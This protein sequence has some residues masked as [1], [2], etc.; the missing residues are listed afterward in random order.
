MFDKEKFL[1]NI[2]YFIILYYIFC[3]FK[4][5]FH[6]IYKKKSL[7][8]IRIHMYCAKCIFYILVIKKYKYKYNI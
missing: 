2:Q 4:E 5:N 3:N 6:L 7:C 1:F 8:M